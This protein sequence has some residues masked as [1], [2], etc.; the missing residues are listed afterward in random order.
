MPV[1][2]NWMISLAIVVCLTIALAGQAGTD[3]LTP[4]PALNTGAVVGKAASS[5]L[6]VF[7]AFAAA[8]L[9]NRLEPLLHTYYVGVELKDQRYILTTMAMIEALDPHIV[10]AYYVAPWVLVKNGKVD[11]ALAMAE[12]GL[13]ANPKSGLLLT[14]LAQLRWIESKDLPGA[15][16]LARRA[17]GDDIAWT[18]IPEQQQSYTTLATIFE[19]YGEPAVG[20]DLRAEIARLDALKGDAGDADG[21]E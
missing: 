21:D 20:A 2:Q 15:V 12:R 14:S 1:R 5:Y 7:K 16:E 3:A 11:D 4:N 17:I 18:D 9:W 10:Q 13:A 19:A 6:T 8:A